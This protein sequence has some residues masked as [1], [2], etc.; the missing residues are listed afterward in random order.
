MLM[1]GDFPGVA[2]RHGLSGRPFFGSY[3]KYAQIPDRDTARGHCRAPGVSVLQNQHDGTAFLDVY[4]RQIDRKANLASGFDF[5]LID[6]HYFYPTAWGDPARSRVRAPVC[7]TPGHDINVY[8]K[9]RLPRRLI[10]WSA[11]EPALITVSEPQRQAC[12]LGVAG[13]KL[14]SCAMAWICV[15]RPGDRAAARARLNLTGN[16]AVV[17]VTCCRQRDMTF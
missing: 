4:G 8:P 7:I 11:P 16:D 3:A 2:P 10:L 17:V 15:F 9:L 1:A 12:R 14:E 5:K 13:D 6:A